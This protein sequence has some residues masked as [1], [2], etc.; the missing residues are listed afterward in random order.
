MTDQ[1]NCT[2]LLKMKPQQHDSNKQSQTVNIGERRDSEWRILAYLGYL[3]YFHITDYDLALIA[4]T[5]IDVKLLLITVSFG[6]A[7][8]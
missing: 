4:Q 7:I 3:N 6:F 8:A 2:V 1:K 5:D